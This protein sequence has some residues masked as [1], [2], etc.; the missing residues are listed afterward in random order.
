MKK[1]I[2]IRRGVAAFFVALAVGT[3]ATFSPAASGNPQDNLKK[4]KETNS[5]RGCDLSG[6]TLG[7]MNLAEA[8]L[9]GADLSRTKFQLSNLSGANLRNAN[10]RGATFGGCD[11]GEADLR[12]ADLRGASLEGAYLEKALLEGEFVTAKP[13]EEIGVDD[14]EKQVYVP[15]PEK[16]KKIPEPGDV[17][18]TTRGEPGESEPS[19]SLEQKKKPSSEKKAGPGGGKV[20]AAP[21]APQSGAPMAK[22]AIPVSQAI[23]EP[24]APPAPVKEEPV[25]RVSTKGSNLGKSSPPPAASLKTTKTAKPAP[26]PPADVKME[27]VKSAGGGLETRDADYST[28]ERERG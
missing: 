9:E 16:S 3:T 13:Y 12:G 4:L 18:V 15:N 6:L 26:V 23:V 8:N 20:V 11:L 14:V 28:E 27:D 21:I 5:C 22:K 2:K 7:R 24:Q 17:K 19:P 25:V 10:L 1:H